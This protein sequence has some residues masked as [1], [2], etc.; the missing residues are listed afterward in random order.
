MQGA[1]DS[2]KDF[3]CHCNLNRK[4]WKVEKGGMEKKSKF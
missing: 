4:P 1:G 2:N 3:I